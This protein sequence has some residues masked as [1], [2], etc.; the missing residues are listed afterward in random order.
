M[1]NN[2]VLETRAPLN[3]LKLDIMDR[4]LPL[5]DAC[6]GDNCQLAAT[7]AA[8]TFEELFQQHMAMQAMQEEMT[9]PAV[10]V[11]CGSAIFMSSAPLEELT[12]DL[13]CR[14]CVQAKG[15][16]CAKGALLKLLKN[17]KGGAAAAGP[18]DHAAGDLNCPPVL[19]HATAAA[20]GLVAIPALACRQDIAGVHASNSGETTTVIRIVTL[21]TAD[22]DRMVW[23]PCEH[24]QVSSAQCPLRGTNVIAASRWYAGGMFQSC[25]CVCDLHVLY[26]DFRVTLLPVPSKS[27][28]NA[29]ARIQVLKHTDAV[30]KKCCNETTT[31]G[32]SQKVVDMDQ[33]VQ[34]QMCM[35]GS[36]TRMMFVSAANLWGGELAS[37]EIRAMGTHIDTQLAS[38]T[39]RPAPLNG[40]GDG[41]GNNDGGGDDYL[42]LGPFG[43]N[44]YRS[45]SPF[46]P[47]SQRETFSILI[48]QLTT[49]ERNVLPVSRWIL[50]QTNVSE[51]EYAGIELVKVRVKNLQLRLFSRHSD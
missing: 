1:L 50:Q 16:A 3:S 39:L 21:S 15:G 29:K 48:S 22:L 30:V 41:G 7:G 12:I 35:R 4:S 36:K 43:G 17:N 26:P 51:L 32:C 24:K 33:D 31:K 14:Y 18:Q 47:N 40:G 37:R 28:S 9:I 49:K 11:H 42:L 5:W 2:L 27:K 34:E 6:H 8:R 19:T 10:A 38:M 25:L 23:L 46:N 20:F 44:N 45:V 13:H